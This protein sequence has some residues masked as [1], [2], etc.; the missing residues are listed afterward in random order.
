LQPKATCC[1]YEL[2]FVDENSCGCNFFSKIGS[3]A[4]D[5]FKIR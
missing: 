1:G 5:E 3:G 2:Q 4:D